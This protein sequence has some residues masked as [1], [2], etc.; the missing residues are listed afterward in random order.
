[1]SAKGELT[2][3]ALDALL[4]RADALKEQASLTAPA[5]QFWCGYAKGLRD[6]QSGG[7][8]KA[9]AK[10]SAAQYGPNVTQGTRA[11]LPIDGERL[12]RSGVEKVFTAESFQIA[13]HLVADFKVDGV[14]QFEHGKLPIAVHN[15]EQPVAVIDVYDFSVCHDPSSVAPDSMEQQAAAE[16][17]DEGDAAA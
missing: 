4:R 13:G 12:A 17:Q 1:M 16:A 14:H 3:A 10:D 5:R 11:A 7:G 15:D 6:L 8:T 2:P 9:A